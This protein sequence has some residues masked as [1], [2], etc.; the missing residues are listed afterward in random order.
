M[1]PPRY[2]STRD[3]VASLVVFEY[4]V[5]HLPSACLVVAVGHDFHPFTNKSAI[6]TTH[7]FP[8]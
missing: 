1:V 7:L 4:S 3:F 6:S 5:A 8:V 2:D